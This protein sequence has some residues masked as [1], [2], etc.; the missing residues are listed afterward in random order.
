[1]RAATTFG[2]TCRWSWPRGPSPVDGDVVRF[3]ATYS[4]TGW[5]QPETS[6]STLLVLGAD[7][8]LEFLGEAGFVVEEEFGNWDRRPL[9]DESPEVITLARRP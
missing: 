3:T 6:H 7:R 8:L 5:V 9:A 4:S 2:S 1:M